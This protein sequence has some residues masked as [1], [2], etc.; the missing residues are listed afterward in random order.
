MSGRGSLSGRSPVQPSPR[1]PLTLSVQSPGPPRRAG[2][3]E[4][5]VFSRL[6]RIT[7]E[8]LLGSS[9]ILFLVI[10]HATPQ[11]RSRSCGRFESGLLWN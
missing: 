2:C 1:A 10:N 7:H 5:H 4:S 8:G 11:T 3:V 6:C 9:E